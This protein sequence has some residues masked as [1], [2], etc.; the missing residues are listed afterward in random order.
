MQHLSLVTEEHITTESWVHAVNGSEEAGCI[1]LTSS[2]P[3]LDFYI[4]TVLVGC[5]SLFGLIGNLVSFLVLQKTNGKLTST[6]V[7]LQGLAFFDSFFILGSIFY[8]SLRSVYPYTGYMTTYW[9]NFPLVQ[10]HV[11]PWWYISQTCSTWMV[12]YITVDRYLAVHHPIKAIIHCSAKRARKMTVVIFLLAVLYNIPRFFEYRVLKLPL[13]C[14]VHYLRYQAS[15]F[16]NTTYRFM[17]AC[18]LYFLTM[19]ILP[20]VIL[21]VCNIQL[22]R[23]VHQASRNRTCMVLSLN[24]RS[25]REDGSIS[26]IVI[27]VILSFILCIGPDLVLQIMFVTNASYSQR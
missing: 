10:V 17:Y 11:L 7:L 1:N 13:H 23:E 22:I 27:A 18:C 26:I 24:M 8:H 14:E 5:L 12:T 15:L 20:L 16:T 6:A 4:D 2:N 3:A 21:I 25:H 19:Y 9:N